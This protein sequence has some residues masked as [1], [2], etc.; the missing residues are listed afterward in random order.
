MD[1]KIYLITGD[2]KGIGRSLSEYYL[3]NGQIVIGCSRTGSDLVHDNYDH[4][5]CD[6]SDEKAVKSL[7]LFIRQKFK[8][9]DGMIELTNIDHIK[10][11]YYGSH[12]EIN[13]S[14]IIPLGPI[15]F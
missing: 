8:R 6:V 15:N 10:T 12:K 4:L 14:G 13:P 11:H 3:S 5:I 9:I 2:R 7:I 1:R